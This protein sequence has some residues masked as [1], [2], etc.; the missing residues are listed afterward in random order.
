MEAIVAAQ[1]YKTEWPP[2]NTVIALAGLV[3][4]TYP[5]MLNISGFTFIYFTAFVF[6]G[7]SIII[8]VHDIVETRH[9][10]GVLMPHRVELH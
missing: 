8:I 1:N 6:H 10:V 9:V 2:G 3:I 7:R 4:K 5:Y